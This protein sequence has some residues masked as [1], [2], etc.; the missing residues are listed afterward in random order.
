MQPKNQLSRFTKWN[1][2]H[3]Q[4]LIKES[5]PWSDTM[6]R[7]SFKAVCRTGSRWSWFGTVS[8][9][10]PANPRDLKTG[11][12]EVLKFIRSLRGWPKETFSAAPIIRGSFFHVRGQGASSSWFGEHLTRR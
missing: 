8:L 5:N 7:R 12:F 6:A 4:G 1:F 3:P 9:S 2:I 11:A 10:S